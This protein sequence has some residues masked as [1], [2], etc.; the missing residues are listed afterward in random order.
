MLGLGFPQRATKAAYDRVWQT[1]SAR[2]RSVQDV[3][4]QT[5][6][7]STQGP[8][9]DLYLRGSPGGEQEVF[10]QSTRETVP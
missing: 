4:H 6:D 1:A 3:I 2:P 9:H 7:G 5:A 8:S 10:G